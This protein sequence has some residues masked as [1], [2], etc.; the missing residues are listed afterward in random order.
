MQSFQDIWP[1]IEANN[2]MGVVKT[3]FLH[4]LLQDVQGIPGS[5]AEIGVYLGHTSRMM[6]L[7]CPDRELH[8][9]DTFQGVTLSQP[10]LDH[11]QDG[12]FSVSYEDVLARVGTDAFYHIGTFPA[13]LE[14]S[15]GPF[16][17]CHSDTDTYFG[18]FATLQT[19]LPMMAKGGILV[20]DDYHYVY[21][22]GVEKAIN[23]F[24]QNPTRK[25]G[26]QVNGHQFV[27][28]MLD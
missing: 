13:T 9:Y 4:K 28:T 2:L 10:G 25:V 26:T 18:T 3:G 24:L 17:F 22:Q 6:R 5:M 11:H 14:Y 1:T 20:F 8:L 27:M 15:H 21:C 12:D 16:A 19:V 7:A 23:D